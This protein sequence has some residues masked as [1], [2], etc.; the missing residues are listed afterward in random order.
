MPYWPWRQ[1]F[2]TLGISAA[3][4]D[5]P[6]GRTTVFAEVADRLAAATAERPAVIILEDM[7]IAD[8]PALALLR[9]VVGVLPELRCLLL[10]TARDN[11]VDVTEPAAE[12]LR[13]MPP[14]VVRLTL[15]GLDRDATGQLVEQVLGTRPDTGYADA[16]YARTGGNPFF[17]QALARLHAA[18]GTTPAEPPTGVRQVL[19]RR[20]ARLSQQTCDVLATASVLGEDVDLDLLATVDGTAPTEVLAFLGD[21][22]AARLATIDGNRVRFAHSLVREV[23][24]AGLGAVRR[25]ELHLR[26]GQA[27]TG[28]C[29]PTGVHNVTHGLP[30][31][32][33]CCTPALVEA[34]A[35]Q[36]AAHYRA[37]VGHPEAAE[38][39][40]EFALIAARVALR[41]S[42]YEQAVHYY[43]WADETDPAVRLEL[44]EA[45]VLAGQLAAGRNTLRGVARDAAA[46]GEV[47]TVARAVLAMG[48]GVGGFEVD[49]DDSEQIRLL[50]RVVPKLPDSGLKAAAVARLALGRT[51]SDHGDKPQRLAQEAITLA[52][53]ARDPR[54]EVAALA[55]WCDVCAGPD[56]VGE[57]IAAAERMLEIAT[58][59]GDVALVLLA[60]RLLVVALLE[61]GRFAE[62][63]VQIAA[64]ARAVLPLR[65][66][67]YSWLVPIWQGMR[68][69]MSGALDDVSTCVARATQL[70]DEADSVNGRLMVF[71]LRAARAH[72]TG[73]VRDLRGYIETVMAPFAGNPMA[74]GAYAYYLAQ[75]GEGE[76]ARGIVR[77]RVHGGLDSIV[78]DAEWLE[79]VALLGEAGRLL[80]DDEA[81]T[82]AL[83]ALTPYGALWVI[84][85]IGGACLGSVSLFLGRFA[86]R[87]GRPDARRL[88]QT[89]LGAHRAAGAETLVAETE[90][91]LAELGIVQVHRTV[92]TGELRRLGA[93]WEATWRGTTTL[94][95]DSK[96]VRDIAVLLTRPR[97]PVS[98]LDLAGPGRATG[99]DLGPVLDDRARAAY[100]ERLHELE[101]DLV[102][103]EA[104]NDP[105][106][107]E[108]A[109]TERDFI[110]RELAA[111]LGIGGRVRS[112]GDP[113]ER[114]RKAVSMRIGAAVKAIERV[115][116]ALGRHLRVSIRTGRQ[117]VYE[118]E[119][120]VTW[121][122]QTTSGA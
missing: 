42:G 94:V 52:R 65:L 92:E 110:A 5:R 104:D 45:Q 21:A 73:T 10:V 62:A 81:V 111:A 105:A 70:A 38:R 74:D 34:N 79:V 68:A 31:I 36:V 88:L 102:E 19:E 117:C 120:D 48:G 112:A 91:A 66:P 3:L 101:E 51:P 50:A 99:A 14:Y 4:P 114:S 72:F 103:A 53:E 100:R 119:D 11:A 39:S 18:R 24:Y 30:L 85:G 15:T 67:L 7:H 118:P 55:A 64:F 13:A 54:A 115:D 41:R 47:E 84:D 122:C 37:A 116:P 93:M 2:R 71:A 49:L 17:V 12:A 25:S 46:A 90:A 75:M 59:T 16:V 121:H 32:D 109:R 106:R 20:L 97:R 29:C 69:L 60:R 44:G 113:V 23:V 98:V 63:D 86:I 80:G 77:R 61:Q 107:A 40:H 27:L 57:R 76:R 95:P 89:A 82:L 58:G 8:G 9:F 78:K 26:A 28:R 108:K 43:G 87:L 6:T 83:D 96:G 22:V 1:A 33:D 35:G 56:H